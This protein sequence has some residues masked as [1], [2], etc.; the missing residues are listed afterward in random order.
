MN[1]GSSCRSSLLNSVHWGKN[2][3][4]G[5]R[6]RR[7]GN[8]AAFLV[9]QHSCGANA[10]DMRSD[11][12]AVCCHRMAISLSHVYDGLFAVNTED[13]SLGRSRRFPT[14]VGFVNGNDAEKCKAD[15]RCLWIE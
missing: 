8:S 9:F 3:S 6:G 1:A 13:S 2:S 4:S 12:I 14:T 10:R 15:M 7:R 5:S 11:A